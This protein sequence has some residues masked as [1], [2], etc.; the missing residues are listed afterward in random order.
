[1]MLERARLYQASNGIWD[2]ARLRSPRR[3]ANDALRKRRR[4]R[5]SAPLGAW[6]M[7]RPRHRCSGARSQAHRD[8]S[9]RSK[10]CHRRPPHRAC[11]LFPSAPPPSCLAAALLCYL[12][13]SR[14]CMMLATQ[15]QLASR[16]QRTGSQDHGV[17][18]RR[19]GSNNGRQM[20]R[21]VL[22]RYL[23]WLRSTAILLATKCACNTDRDRPDLLPAEHA[24]KRATALR[25]NLK[26]DGD[27][28]HES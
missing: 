16:R 2:D 23:C 4:S 28:K 3:R 26:P 9:A 22:C 11:L 25:A 21:R 19:I 12:H 24:P 10:T 18:V 14:A 1:M 20:L 8:G 5:A 6:F 15:S 7:R 13:L 17:P 27:S